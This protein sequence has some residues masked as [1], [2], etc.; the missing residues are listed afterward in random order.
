MD[1]FYVCSKVFRTVVI[2]R[3]RRCQPFSVS[4]RC[5][6]GCPLGGVSLCGVLRC[7]WGYGRSEFVV[8]CLVVLGLLFW[9]SSGSG[10]LLLGVEV[11]PSG[12][13]R[14]VWVGAGWEFGGVTGQV[15]KGC[16]G[17]SPRCSSLGALRR[18]N[19]EPVVCLLQ[20]VESLTLS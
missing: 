2:P 4:L 1:L 12:R 20:V 15:W 9:P 11:A 19:P 6:E 17:W 13:V 8:F 14:G 10:V 7:M 3:F 5:L 18:C 16:Q